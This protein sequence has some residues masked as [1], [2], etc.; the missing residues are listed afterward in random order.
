MILARRLLPV[1]GSII[2][3]ACYAGVLFQPIQWVE[4]LIAA[5]VFA[6]ASLLF[7][8]RWRWNT[9]ETWFAA[10][11]ILTLL[12]GG[13][14]MLF[15][16]EGLVLRCVAAAALSII[17]GVYMENL[18]TL[19]FQPSKYAS[20]S[21]PKLSLVLNVI[22]AFFLF[23]TAFALQLIGLIQFWLISVLALFYGSLHMAYMLRG[24]NVAPEKR[25]G[26]ILFVGIIFAELITV[27]GFLPTGFY[28]DGLF[29]AIM[30]YFLTTFALMIARDAFSKR[31]FIEQVVLAVCM[32][33]ILFATAQWT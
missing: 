13:T 33:I 20:L 7:M 23:S 18:F 15:F 28:V 27:I 3:I 26:F 9:A 8:M 16:I 32:L 11:P 22:T 6:V 25:R 4:W 2:L 29:A 19:H 14:G 12:V 24:F 31:Q 1:I 10:F 5:A 17:Y 30:V 21:L